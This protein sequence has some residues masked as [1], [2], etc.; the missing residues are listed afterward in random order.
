[1][2]RLPG[3]RRRDDSARNSS[4]GSFW[5]PMD[6]DLRV[7]SADLLETVGC[8]YLSRLSRSGRH[9][10]LE[11]W[12]QHGANQSTDESLVEAPL[13]SAFGQNY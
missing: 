11:G 3:M 12:N 13:E 8:I 7:S 5:L 6:D 9:V 10:G 1:M 4:S 2:W